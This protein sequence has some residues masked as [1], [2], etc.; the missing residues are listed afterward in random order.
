MF[1]TRE[2]S[3]GIGLVVAAMAFGSVSSWAIDYQPFDWVPLP[4]GTSVVMGYYAFGKYDQYN[5]TV[6]GTVKKNTGLN[7]NVG[8]TRYLYYVQPEI[9][10][11][12]WYLDVVLPFGGLDGKIGG[13]PLGK[14][15]GIGD[16]LVSS[17]LWFINEP[18]QKRWLS[19]GEYVALPIGTYA[20]GRA[21]NLG[22]NRWVSQLQADFTQG[23]GDQ[24][25]VDV[26]GDWT[27]YSNN[28][29]AGTG[30]QRLTQNDTYDCYA[31][32]SYE[33]TDFVRYTLPASESSAWLSFG[34]A[35]S[36]GGVQ[37]VDGVRNGAQTRQ[38]QLRL[39][40][41]IALTPT[42]QGLMLV[43][44]DLAVSGQFKQSFGLLL[45]I[46]KSF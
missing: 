13:N 6:T 19:V 31:W 20:K 28:N 22:G 7:S 8:I 5:S 2:I 36:F 17:G 3:S 34:Y 35:G 24:F 21:L 26:S 42:W 25:A 30:H 37:R 9:F 14:P 39:S 10:G 38:D 41:L 23:L 32:L 29:Q 43:S 4:A 40:Y 44:R 1:G 46:S 12:Q 18:N 15:V 45:R 11:R 33:L 16:P 27:Y